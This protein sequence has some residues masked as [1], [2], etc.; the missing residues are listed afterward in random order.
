MLQLQQPF[1]FV[2]SVLASLIIVAVAAGKL[3]PSGGS[4]VAFVPSK[5]RVECPTLLA[6]PLEDQNLVSAP[7]ALLTGWVPLWDHHY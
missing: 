6:T 4:S 7:L 2:A 3:Q 5:K 1:A